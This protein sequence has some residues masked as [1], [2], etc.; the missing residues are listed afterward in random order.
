M[1]AN[2]PGAGDERGRPA[3]SER[4]PVVAYEVDRFHV[5][6]YLRV[7]YRRRWLA[8]TVFLL[9]FLSA[10]IY[11]VTATPVYEATVRLQIEIETPNVTPFREVVPN[12]R[13]GMRTEFYRTQY[14][15]LQSRSLARTT[16]DRLALWDH[17]V[18]APASGTAFNPVAWVIG[19]I[20]EGVSF[21]LQYL[22]A[23]LAP[24]SPPGGGAGG[25]S[26]PIPAPKPVPRRA[27]STPSWPA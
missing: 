11:A 10:F 24:E 3:A 19:K 14:E 9:V 16:M 25:G 4:V 20:I 15:I 7:V 5:A 18:L 22:S 27:R 6:D 26:A 1:P 13:W 23:A 21:P 8:A 2:G 17:P 12:S